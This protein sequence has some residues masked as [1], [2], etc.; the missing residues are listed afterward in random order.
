MYSFVIPCF[1]ESDRFERLEQ[2]IQRYDQYSTVPVEVILVND[3]STDGTLDR[4]Q[5][6]AQQGFEWTSVKVLDL[7]KNLGKGGALRAGVLSAGGDFVLT[8]DADMSTDPMQL[9][10]W[11][12]KLAVEEFDSDTIRIANRA[13]P[14]SEIKALQNRKSLGGFFNRY[15]KMITPLRQDDTQC[16]FKL[17]PGKIAKTLFYKLEDFGW[18]HDI[19]LLCRAYYEGY[20]VVSLPVKWQHVGQAKINV[21]SDGLKMVLASGR[22]IKRLKR[23]YNSINT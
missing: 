16:G 5:A 13:H 2:A 22:I 7:E 21:Y 12:K 20:K 19:E 3:G 17:Y 9:V 18:A 8:L 6:F 1:N 15:V 10:A 23:E 11:K 14:E 4:M